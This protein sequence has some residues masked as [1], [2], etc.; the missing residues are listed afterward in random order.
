[1]ISK[2][3]AL[4]RRLE[5]FNESLHQDFRYLGPAT[6]ISSRTDPYRLFSLH[7]MYHFCLCTLHSSIVPVLSNTTS[8]PRISKK[9]VRMS[10]EETVRH[11]MFIL[12]ISTAFSNTSPE[13]VRLPSV[14]GFILFSSCTVYFKSLGA[15]GR[16]CNTDTTRWNGALTIL[17]ALKDYFLPLQKQVCQTIEYFQYFGLTES[18]DDPRFPLLFRKY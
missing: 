14:V 13:I 16:L 6:F 4:D 1:M 10:A 5:V 15:Q 12:D 9:L 18:V 11:S 17:K 8:N 7:C 3:L 2:L